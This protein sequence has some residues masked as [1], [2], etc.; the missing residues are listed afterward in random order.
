MTSTMASSPEQASLNLTSKIICFIQCSP[1]MSKPADP[2]EMD[3]SCLDAAEMIVASLIENLPDTAYCYFTSN[4]DDPRVGEGLGEMLDRYY[5]KPLMEKREIEASSFLIIA[6]RY[7]PEIPDI[8]K[9]A[10]NDALVIPE[11]DSFPVIQIACLLMTEEPEVIR[12][13]K[14]LDEIDGCSVGVKTYRQS[15]EIADTKRM[16]G[17]QESTQQTGDGQ[18]GTKP[19]EDEEETTEN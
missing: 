15:M 11:K 7:D 4:K 3:K 5:S 17:E 9:K 8:I 12:L 18:E 1:S 2:D 13:Y 19:V 16:M 10:R 14:K 6:D